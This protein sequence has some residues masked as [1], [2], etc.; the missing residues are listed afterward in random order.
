[1]DSKNTDRILAAASDAAGMVDGYLNDVLKNTSG[2]RSSIRGSC[3]FLLDDLEIQITSCEI[4]LIRI[5]SVLAQ[6]AQFHIL[7]AYHHASPSL[8][9]FLVGIY[10]FVVKVVE[11]ITVINTIMLVVTGEKLAYWLDQLIPGFQAAWD[12]IM[13]KI[14]AFSAALGWGVDGVQHLLNAT[15]ASADIWGTVT[16]KDLDSVKM[17]KFKRTEILLD[18]Y[19]K[20][21]HAWQ[22]NPGQQIAK[23]AEAASSRMYW[24]GYD[25]IHNIT[26]KVGVFGE[27]VET[28]LTS[29]GTITDELLSLRNDMPE[30]I[31]E[32][33]PTGIWDSLEKADTVINDRILP[34]LTTITDR[35]DDL[36]AVL[37][38]YQAK[39]AEIADRLAHPGDLLAEIDKLPD[40]AR[41]NQLVKIDGVTSMLMKESNEAAVAALA[42]DLS[43]FGI[44]AASLE[45]PPA[46][47]PFM[48]LELP[49]RSPGITPEPYETWILDKDY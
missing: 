9:L 18:S 27:K 7:R 33:I 17:E 3:V 26:D 30:F 38:A 20:Y 21:L 23:Y 16:G 25:A 13:N 43:E 46:P 36:D 1:M 28:V 34:A 22:A 6:N 48:T 2:I 47:L 29:V 44:I 12:D 42:G 31:A 37:D 32:N 41:Q 15:H 5:S 4:N 11:I 24:S 45:N 40:Y 49:G 39:A 35:I 10:E 19:S 8:W 14:S